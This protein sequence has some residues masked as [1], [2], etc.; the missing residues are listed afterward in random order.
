MPESQLARKCHLPTQE[1]NDEVLNKKEK[2]TPTTS[3]AASDGE[4]IVDEKCKKSPLKSNI[5]AQNVES[6]E[7]KL[8]NSP[9]I[10]PLLLCRNQ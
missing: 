4:L 8:K 9:A 3:S 7:Q 5:V 2:G 1:K 6:V 10:L